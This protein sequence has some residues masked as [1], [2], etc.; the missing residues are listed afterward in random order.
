M[1]KLKRLIPMSLGLVMA[2]SISFAAACTETGESGYTVT[3]D[4]NGGTAIASQQIDDGGTIDEPTEPQFGGYTFKGWYYNGAEY[5]FSSVV[6][7]DMTLSAVWEKIE[8]EEPEPEPE[9]EPEVYIVSFDSAGG[10]Y[11]PVQKVEEGGSA[12]RPSNPVYAGHTFEGWYLNGS[13][14]NFSTPVTDDIVLTAH[15]SN[16][17]TVTFN[18]N[19]GSVVASQSVAPGGRISKPSDPVFDG[20]T[21]QGWYY[22]GAEYDFS[23]TV[24]SDMVITAMWAE[25]SGTSPSDSQFPVTLAPGG[26]SFTYGW[27]GEETTVQIDEKNIYVDGRLTDEQIEGVDNV[28]NS[29][30]DAMNNLT[31]GTESE[32]MNVYIAPYVYWIH[33]PYS[34]STTEA[35]GMYINCKNLHITGLTDDPYNVVIAGNYGHNEGYDGGNWTMFSVSG[36]GLN[37]RN[38]T[39]GDY[40]NV[41]L[42]YPLDPSLS[43]PK[44]TDNITQG[45]IA[46]YRGDKLYAENCNFISRLNMMPFNN[47]QRALYVNCHMES[48]DDSLNGSSKAVYL[49]CDFEFYG[50]KPWGGSSGVTLLDCTMTSCN[51]NVRDSVSQYLS[52]GAGRFTVIDCRFLSDYDVPVTFGWSDVISESFRSYYS[53]VTHNGEQI[54]IDDGGA[55]PD[56]CV[57]ITGTEMLKAYKLVD[58]NGQIV[59]N[60]YNLL[61]GTDDWDPLGQKEIVTKLGATDIATNMTVS[62][63]EGSSEIEAG[64]STATLTYSLSGPQNSDYTSKA[65]VTWSVAPEDEQYVKLTPSADGTTCVVESLNDTDEIPTVVV[66]ATDESGLQGAVALQVRAEI[67]PAP[68]FTSDPVIRQN[69][70][71]T[72]QVDYEISGESADNSYIIWSVCDDAQG[73]NAI[74]IAVGRM[75]E[76]LKVITLDQAYVGKYLQVS[77]LRKSVRS[78][79]ADVADVYI[80]ETPIAQEGITAGNTLTTD[81]S[82][83]STAPQTDVIKGM[84]TVDAYCPED[85]QAG[86]IP[87]DGTEVDGKYS[88]KVGGKWTP[89][90][91]NNSISSWNYGTGAKVGYNGYSG[92]M[93]TQRGARIMYTPLEE[94]YSDMDV[95]LM[96]APG[97]EASQGFGSDYQYM[98]IMI[99]FDTETLTGYGLRI[100]RKSGNSCEFVLMEH[101]DGKSKEICT[102]V[103]SAAYL[104]EC[105]I[106]VWTEDGNLNA[107]VESSQIPD[108]QVDLSV[109]M[110]KDYN[111]GG[112][113]LISTGTTGDNSTYLCNLSMEWTK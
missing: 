48:T 63:S 41:D 101:R 27:E 26:K 59:Y 56:A 4:S 43:M 15:W 30:V 47:S 35:Y 55:R 13:L 1:K 21:F 85:T 77:I 33:N 22:N 104:T 28:Y 99:Q 31:D 92:I 65:K 108:D 70:D 83:F 110:D 71:G 78:D 73:T 32:P 29:F 2:V 60:V 96:V 14:Y 94:E 58:E 80:L 91:I 61:R 66:M 51:Y 45:Q 24:T 57:D 39:F 76:P 20:Y 44:R 19:G 87:L 54:A 98:D 79:Y 93:N 68:E 72:A 103:E 37:L 42:E 97:K 84:W 16:L 34:S 111:Y 100:Y 46:S 106:H 17:Y 64:A 50:T 88:D 52:K 90:N 53:N 12:T 81:F 25:E 8:E 113:C 62:I 36:D 3:F 49:G 67:L 7:S 112:F 102:P 18:T 6:T 95:T 74:E 105:T 5:D 9:P 11:V 86:Y 109:K 75:D 107:H 40:C 89:A 23:S 38:V 69:A 10:G 82:T